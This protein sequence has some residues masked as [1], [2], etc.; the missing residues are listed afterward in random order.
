MKKKILFLIATGLGSGYSPVIPGTAGSL[1]ALL[2]IYFIPLDDI[3]WLAVV[4]IFFVIGLWSSNVVEKETEKD[5]KI[6]VI[7]EIVGQWIALLF[8]PK[9]LW[10]YLAGFILF[11]LLDILKPFPIMEME[12]FEGGTGIMLDDVVAGIYTNVALNLTLIFL[13]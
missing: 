9:I 8:L 5:P 11:R 10:I 6:V 1:L 13:M 2:L 4:I 7:D 3:I 12:E